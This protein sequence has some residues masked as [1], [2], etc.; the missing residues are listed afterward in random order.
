MAS[1]Y[2]AYGSNMNPA[3][4]EER[5][6]EVRA[7]L[8]GALTGYQLVFDKVSRAHPEHSHANVVYA[9]GGVVEGV[10]YELTHA[11]E[12]LKMDRFESAPVNYG[13]E[14]V[15]I[16]SGDRHIPAW[17]YFANPAVRRPGLH[18]PRSYLAHLLAGRAYLSDAY[19]SW[20]EEHPCA[21]D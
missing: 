14:V 20:L 11:N 13:R 6:L 7:V 21:D 18:P 19:F 16:R 2:F 8:P 5:G 15:Q 3:R 17:T 4:V 12:I 10:L 9:P 1:F